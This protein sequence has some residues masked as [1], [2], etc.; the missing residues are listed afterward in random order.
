MPLLFPESLRNTNISMLKRLK[1]FTL[2]FIFI[3]SLQKS[4]AWG[5]EGHAIVG[6]L[7]M[8]FVKD[9][10]RKNLLQLLG[11]MPVDT[12]AN[13]MDIMK[14]NTDYDFMRSWHYVDFPKGQSYQSTNTDNALNR[15]LLSYNELT[16]KKLL[17]TEQVR[18]DLFILLHLMGDLHMPLHTGYDEDLGGNR[19]MVQ[20]G[21]LKDHN[22]H[23]FW[24]EDIIAL[25]K[26]TDADCLKHLNIYPDTVK[27]IEFVNWMNE[28]RLLLPEVYAFKGYQVDDAYLDKNKVVVEKQLLLAGLRLAAVLNKLFYTP[29][30]EVNFD[31]VTTTYKNGIHV[32]E[33]MNNI[34]KKVTVCAKVFSVRSTAAITQINIGGKFPNTPLTVVIFGKSYANFQGNPEDLF[35]DKNICVR[36]KIEEYKGK[37]QI[38]VDSPED[39][40]TL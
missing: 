13:W 16:H 28:S 29:A 26:I 1:L 17:C 30:A 20:Y 7:A 37:A 14:S 10:V 31:A 9:D 18:T 40:T 38:I 25:K 33:S 36:G 21:S 19:V 22:L 35:K 15:L 12:A 2:L 3:V 6:R 11:N 39:I 27:S 4:F 34:G 24:D 8:R 23:R 5:P 32:S